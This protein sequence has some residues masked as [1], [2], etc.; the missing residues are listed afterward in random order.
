M[1]LRGLDDFQS[2]LSL[3]FVGSVETGAMQ[4]WR[5]IPDTIKTV[6]IRR[7]VDQVVA[8]FAKLGYQLDVQQIRRLDH[9]LDQIEARVPHVLRIDFDDLNTEATCAKLFEHC[10]GVPHDPAWWRLMASVNLQVDVHHVVRY[11]AAHKPQ[12]DKLAKIAKSTILAKLRPD[13]IDQDDG[14][15]FREET[16]DSFLEAAQAELARHSMHFG[17]SP[18]SW[19]D[20]NIPLFYALEQSNSLHIVT[21]RSNGRVFG[22]C[23]SMIS[24]N[25]ENT[26]I[27][28]NQ[29]YFFGFGIH[30]IGMRLQRHV[31][32]VLR[33]R[34]VDDVFFHV[35]PGT[36][37][38][39]L[40]RRL[41][42]VED[43]TIYRLPI[44]TGQ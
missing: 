19:M 3:P 41:G 14:L 22:H 24:P 18:D 8:S 4:F 34:G 5:M 10:L 9:K 38:A 37:T 7:P 40:Y 31:L 17:E 25:T 28:A 16:V 44:T 6:T 36:R 33:A 29:L 30:R 39:P 11:Y 23:I 43:G 2:W 12:L 15:T 27:S 35:A 1:H 20:K 21:A 42:A 32:D 13:E 26:R